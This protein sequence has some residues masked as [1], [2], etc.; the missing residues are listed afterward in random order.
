MESNWS[1][2]LQTLEDH[3]GWVGSVVFSHDGTH[4][5][6]ASGDQTIKI[7]DASS[8]KC[9]QTLNIGRSL[10]NIL[11]DTTGSFLHTEI[12]TFNLDVPSAS[13]PVQSTAD[14]RRPR[15][16]GYGL[17]SNNMW[18]MRG[19]ENLLWLPSEY[20]SSASAISASTVAIGCP[21]GRVLIFKFL[22]S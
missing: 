12:G 10:S 14:Y 16:H 17:N 3:S 4:L 8:G 2:C 1:S 22:D 20:R 21:S 6:S 11:F 9:L 15:R 13:L 18:I 5:A 19:Y 7:W